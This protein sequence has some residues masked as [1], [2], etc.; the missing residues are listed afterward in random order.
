MSEKETVGTESAAAPVEAT[1]NIFTDAPYV[2][3]EPTGDIVSLKA[4]STE[5]VA[6]LVS[7]F[8]GIRLQ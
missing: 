1:P 3:E 7:T 2:T 6:L 4:G 5:V 8:P